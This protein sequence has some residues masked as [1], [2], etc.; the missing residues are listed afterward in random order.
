ME[1][2]TKN[3]ARELGPYNVRCNAILPGGI[4]NDRLNRIL[5]RNAKEADV[6]QQEYEKEALRYVSMR[7]KIEPEEL[8]DT[9]YFLG[10]DTAPHI[11][12]LSMEVSGG[13]EWEE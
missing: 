11:T 5:E 1:G 13:S 4:N 6:T 7:C 10:T 8:A 12:G 3:A 9:V 2:L